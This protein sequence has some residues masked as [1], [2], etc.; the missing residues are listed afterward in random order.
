MA[1]KRKTKKDNK[2][3]DNR[4]KKQLVNMVLTVCTFATCL[5]PHPGFSVASACSGW[6][7][8]IFALS[9]MNARFTSCFGCDNDPVAKMLNV[10]THNHHKWYDDC[11][12][13]DFQA[14]PG[15]DLFFAGFPCQTFSLAGSG[16]G[17][18]DDQGRGVIVM[19][20]IKW[21]SNHLPKAFVL[22]NVVGLLT[23]HYATF[24]LI[25]ELL[26][27][28]KNKNGKPA[29]TITWKLMNCRLHGFI[30]QNRKRIFITG[31][32][33]DLAQHD[34]RW[35][36]EARLCVIASYYV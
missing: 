23:L 31:I 26:M 5:D 24:L 21:I 7:S 15:A 29:Y 16:N 1:P 27:T 11:T 2:K 14:S 4:I 32:R 25:I 35:P 33:T 9:S 18:Y 28:I 3:G 10:A 36:R 8:E 19:Y 20:L 30:P 17:F 34:M 6:S 13:E 22:E 12:H